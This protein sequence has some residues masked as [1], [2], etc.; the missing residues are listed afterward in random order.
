LET[1]QSQSGLQK[2]DANR[3]S[4]ESRAQ[5]TPLC[6]S[7][8]VVHCSPLLCCLKV[9]VLLHLVLSCLPR[10]LRP[11]LV[12]VPC[13]SSAVQLGLGRNLSPKRRDLRTDLGIIVIAGTAIA[14]C[15]R[16]E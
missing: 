11:L 5:A 15:D 14:S 3:M 16:H 7:D 10:H 2:A 13:C 1:R 8:C 9:H 6:P 4:S 12:C